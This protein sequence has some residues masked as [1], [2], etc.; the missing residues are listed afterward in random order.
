MSSPMRRL[1]LKRLEIRKTF[2]EK[3]AKH[4]QKNINLKIKE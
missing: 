1:G 2:L 4:F 3:F